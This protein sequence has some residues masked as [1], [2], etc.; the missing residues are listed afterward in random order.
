MYERYREW[1][2]SS[3]FCYK[4]GCVCDG[5]YLPKI[6]ESK[7]FM[8]NAV[9]ELV[10]KFGMPKEEEILSKTELQIIDA[11]KS[12]ASDWNSIMEKCKI[13]KTKL[14]YCLGK[15][16]K[17]AENEGVIYETQRNK[18]K[19]LVEWIRKAKVI[20]ENEQ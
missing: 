20:Q 16:Y 18:L 4:R 8:K 5:C 12:G 15:L 11:I 7:C 3:I 9:I 13:K 2:D 17:L 19:Q 10:K 6:M 1:T 14:M